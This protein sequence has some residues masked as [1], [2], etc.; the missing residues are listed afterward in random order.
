[1][2]FAFGQS[3]AHVTFTQLHWRGGG[4]AIW[5]LAIAGLAAQCGKHQL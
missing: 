2:E 4:S 3:A 1:M 5:R